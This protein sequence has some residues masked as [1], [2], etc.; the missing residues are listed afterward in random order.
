MIVYAVGILFVIS[1]IFNCKLANKLKSMQQSARVGRDFHQVSAANRYLAAQ[2]NQNRTPGR[3]N[4]TPTPGRGV[5]YRNYLREAVEG[6]HND[7]GTMEEPLLTAS[8]STASDDTERVD[9]TD[10]AEGVE[11]SKQEAE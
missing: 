11:E 6:G 3:P 9:N 5:S 7:N 10:S 8:T 1:L 2:A 4:R